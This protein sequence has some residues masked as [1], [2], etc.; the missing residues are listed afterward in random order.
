MEQDARFEI[1]GVGSPFV[2]H[3]LCVSQE[4][5]DQ[6]PGPKHGREPISYEELQQII[7]SSGSRPHL[8]SGGSCANT[9]KGLAG[10]GRRCALTGRVGED[11]EGEC[12]KSQLI[13]DGVTPLLRPCPTPTGHVLSL[14]TP[15][16]LRT[17]RT[18]PGAS[19][20][21]GPEDL[22]EADF[23][24]VKLVHIEGYTIPNS[25]LINKALRLAKAAGSRISLDLGC[26]EIVQQHKTAI[27]EM[28]E[29]YIDILFTNRDE[30]L[31]LAGLPPAEACQEISSLVDTAVVMMGKNGAWVGRKGKI[32]RCPALSVTA[33]DTTG[34][35]D[36]F[37]SGFLHGIL[38]EIPLEECA[39]WGAAAAA[40]VVEV[41]GAEIR[42]VQWGP[43]RLLTAGASPH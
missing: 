38:S 26:F 12:L 10:F 18:Y 36:L 2:D 33:V 11:P 29:E 31:A 41:V 40:A 43:L 34:A 21:Q 24:G 22:S 6:L 9:L 17:C 39:R 32:H 23:E 35:G 5:L 15:D 4:F 30:A 13:S 20:E 27:R 14:V 25:A 37:A 1:L 42:P 7:T 28:L 16:S 19:A 8:A 3:V